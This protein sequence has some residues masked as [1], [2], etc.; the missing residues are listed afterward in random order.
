MEGNTVIKYKNLEVR[1]STESDDEINDLLASTIVGS[2]GGMQYT[3]RNIPARIANYGTSIRLVSL[4]RN[5]SLAAVIGTCHRECSLGGTLHNCIYLRF[6]SFRQQYQTGRVVHNTKKEEHEQHEGDSFRNQALRIFSKPHLL[7]FP[8]V[9]EMGKSILYAFV[10]SK[11]ERSKNLIQKAGYEYIRSFLTLAFSR[12]NPKPDI[13]VSVASMNE[14]PEISDEL[15]S[16][17]KEY[18]FYFD[19]F[20]FHN[21]SYYVLRESGRIVAGVSAVPTEYVIKNVPGVWGWIMM[22]VLPFFPFFRRLF[23][24]GLFRF[25]SLGSIFYM[26]GREDAL[27]PLFES[28]CA[29]TGLNTCLTWADDRGPLY[30]VLRTRVSMGA[31]NRMLNAKPGLVYARFVNYTEEE[32]EPFYDAPAFIAG[33]DFS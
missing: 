22:K 3:M 5:Y 30:D 12:F 2:E 24:P 23:A 18:S 15:R 11:N 26:P 1:V 14:Y 19:Q 27:A 32:K 16:F 4:I 20:A 33:F 6:L 21:D 7:G 29:A 13:R 8:G 28:V 17:Y 10:E 9:E 25:V 31:L